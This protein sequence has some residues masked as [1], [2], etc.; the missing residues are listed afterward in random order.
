MRSKYFLAAASLLALL[1]AGSSAQALE[2]EFVFTG[3]VSNF[4]DTTGNTFGENGASLDGASYIATFYI[5]TNLGTL[6]PASSVSQDVGQDLL[7]GS[8][9]SNSSPVTASLEINNVTQ[10]FA[11]APGAQGNS[12]AAIAYDSSAGYSGIAAA[13]LSTE[14]QIVEGAL[15]PTVL[16]ETNFGDAVTILNTVPSQTPYLFTLPTAAGDLITTSGTSPGVVNFTSA[17]PEP[18]SWLLMIMGVAV[19]GGFLRRRG[20]I[21]RL[22]LLNQHA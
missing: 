1:G 13:V 11:V 4:I 21:E 20:K 22:S 5:N 10:T 15:T 12:A 9:F 18:S 16:S 6:T 14:G 19:A 7:G 2:T 3:V 17:A 8:E